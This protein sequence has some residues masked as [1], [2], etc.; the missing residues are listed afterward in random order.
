MPNGVSPKSAR[1][2]VPEPIPEGG[3][4][5]LG[6]APRGGMIE[7][8]EGGLGEGGLGEGGMGGAGGVGGGGLMRPFP[9]IE[10]PI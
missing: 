3:G 6:G 7:G 1:A 2:S 10:P 5:P 4:A 8:G 9:G